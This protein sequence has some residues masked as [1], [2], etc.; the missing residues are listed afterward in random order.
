MKMAH[1]HISKEMQVAAA[2]GVAFCLAVPTGANAA[3]A[4]AGVVIENTAV[5][6]YTAGSTTSTI[7]SNTVKV[8]VDELLDVTLAGL[9][10]S[11]STGSGSEAVLA[12]S[13]VNTGNGPEAFLLSA[14]PAV[15]G[16]DF[17]TQIKAIAID[18]NDNGTYDPGVDQLLASG[19]STPSVEPDGTLKVFVLV[20]IP[21]DAKDTKTSQVTLRAEAVTGSGAPGTSFPGQGEGGGDAVVGQ[22]GANA[23]ALDSLTV[24]AASVAL[25]K[26]ASV[27]NRFGNGQPIPGA[28]ITY[29]IDAAVSGSG[30]VQDLS[31][32]DN[33]PTG[34]TYQ[35]GSLALDG[36]ALSD[37]SDADA[38]SASANGIAVQLGT[39]TGGVSRSVT[40]KV[41]IN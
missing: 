35:A 32:S 31:V 9:T 3:G 26:S 37:A 36:N 13:L 30:T 34:T 38:G 29:R 21:S 11:A 8:R 16:N 20:A 10:S 19:A 12:Y 28:I 27:I 39:I 7:Q 1:G 4:K 41:K 6:S 33:I 23:A 17:D 5:A 18:S 15:V 14:D 40:F 24:R 25:T 2:C 22:S